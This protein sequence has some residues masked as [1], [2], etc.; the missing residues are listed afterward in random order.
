VPSI[1]D[2]SPSTLFSDQWVP[3]VDPYVG[4][5]PANFTAIDSS[6]IPGIRNAVNSVFD[7]VGSTLNDITS[8]IPRLS[9]GDGFPS[10][11]DSSKDSPLSELLGSVG[12]SLPVFSNTSVSEAGSGVLGKVIPGLIPQLPTISGV[13][14]PSI[15]IPNINLPQLPSLDVPGLGK[16]KLPTISPFTFPPINLGGTNPIDLNKIFKN[17]LPSISDIFG[18]KSLTPHMPGAAT[19]VGNYPNAWTNDHTLDETRARY[20]P[21]LPYEWVAVLNDKGS[22]VIDPIY[23]DA[24]STPSVSFENKQRFSGGTYLNYAGAMS[25]SNVTISLY[26]DASGSA[27]IMAA[28]WISLVRKQ[29]TGDYSKP[30]DYKKNIIIYVHDARRGVIVT[31]NLIGCYPVSWASYPLASTGTGVIETTLELSVD[32]F[33]VHDPDSSQDVPPR[34]TRA[35][36]ANDPVN[37]YG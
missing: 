25:V 21:V 5:I 34:S 24:I 20:D 22:T 27:F 9:R 16:I 7:E 10:I 13:S 15:K 36:S 1:F 33:Y 18:G 6:P 37:I 14:L 3:T 11:L 2:S 32:K 29:S 4:R 19:A 35:Q 31:M 28:N 30:V 17:G 26:T 23:I 12:N 8:R